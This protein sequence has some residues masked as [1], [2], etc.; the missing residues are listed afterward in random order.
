MDPVPSINKAYAM[1]QS[2]EKQKQVHMDLFENT[3]T[4]ALHVKGGMRYEK[5]KFNVDNELN[6]V[7]IV[8]RQG[9]SKDTCFKL[10]GTPDCYKEFVDKKRRNAGPTREGWVT[11]HLLYVDS[12]CDIVCDVCPMAKQHRLPFTPSTIHS[13][14]I[15]ELVHID[16]WGPY[17]LHSLTG[18][19]YFLTIVD[20][21][22]R[23]TWTFLLKFFKEDI[24]P[25][26]SAS[27]SS[28]ST[29]VSLP[30]PVPDTDSDPSSFSSP[31]LISSA[32]VPSSGS[33]LGVGIRVG[34]FGSR[35]DPIGF[36]F[37]LRDFFLKN[38]VSGNPIPKLKRSGRS[39]GR[40]ILPEL[41]D[42][43][44]KQLRLDSTK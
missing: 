32:V 7:H 38:G 25:F 17:H 33:Q 39:S 35:P 37:F 4:T 23:T 14:H 18:C 13:H 40:K 36:G 2:V 9:H 16:R 41:P 31:D 10:H 6:I 1:V 21:F 15:L 22:S 8:T 24:F 43:K 11:P 3:E 30:F 29:L 12:H 26:Q 20:D 34:F 44:L 27:P 42:Q 28:D 19:N 5:K